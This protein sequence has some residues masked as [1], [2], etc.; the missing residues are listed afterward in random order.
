LQ[1]KL[2]IL[3]LEDDHLQAQD[4]KTEL[5]RL[6]LD[7]DVQ[8]IDSEHGFMK[9]LPQIQANPPD[10]A[11]LDRMV[12]WAH[13]SPDMPAPPEADWDPEHAGLRCAELLQADKLTK[14]TKILLYSVLGEDG[15]ING[16]EC[17]VKDNDF[18]N[19]L[20]RVKALLSHQP[21]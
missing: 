2:Q 1:E 12:R 17:I 7:V 13:P 14:S 3:V 19:L 16:F 8:I 4:L 9:A 10:L 20:S 15:D 6:D 18:D 21:V 5:E 11:I